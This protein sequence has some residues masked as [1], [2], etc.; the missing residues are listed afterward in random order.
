MTMIGEVALLM[1]VLQAPSGTLSGAKA[2]YAKRFPV[3]NRRSAMPD[4]PKNG[5]QLAG[6]VPPLPPGVK[7]FG[8]DPGRTAKTGRT[9]AGRSR[10]PAYEAYLEMYGTKAAGKLA[11]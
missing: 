3:D 7:T 5:V 8:G 10:S 4:R 6:M 2:G 11:E 1:L 9:K